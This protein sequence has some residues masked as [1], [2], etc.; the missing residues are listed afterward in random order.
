M[1]LQTLILT[2]AVIALAGIVNYIIDKK[3]NAFNATRQTLKKAYFKHRAYAF[4]IDF[5]SL[6][7]VVVLF[8]YL[9]H[10]WVERVIVA[11]LF[12]EDWLTLLVVLAAIFVLIFRDLFK[13]QS[14][15][16]RLLKIAV[17]SVA[18]PAITPPFGKLVLRNI[19]MFIWPI[20]FIVL[21]CSIGDQRKI[22]DRLAGTDVYYI[23]ERSSAPVYL[24]KTNRSLNRLVFFS[25]ITFGIYSLVF[26]YRLSEDINDI[27]SK[28]DGRSTMNF[29]WLF[30]LAPATFGI[31]LHVWFHR[32][33]NRAGNELSRRGIN[34]SFNAKTY[35]LFFGAPERIYF[36]SFMIWLN[37]AEVADL[38]VIFRGLDTFPL[39]LSAGGIAVVILMLVY[40]HKLCV[41]FNLL[42]EHC[43]AHG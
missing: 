37:F 41:T 30:F 11:G 33:S 40:F 25:I 17:R 3:R 18:D 23:S 27:A 14:P 6:S 22:G 16:K 8:A 19:F 13:G 12:L 26:L 29:L 9:I 36:V 43:N 28:H 42:S 20:E 1:L 15:G 4:M 38:Y 39:L 35:W 21:M 32:I 31:A 34:S 7:A 2:V 24:L 5:I 10:T